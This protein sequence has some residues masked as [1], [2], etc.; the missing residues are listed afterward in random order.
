M[1]LLL[2]LRSLGQTPVLMEDGLGE[3]G[4][5]GGEIDRAIVVVGDEDLGRRRG[6]IGRQLAI[7]LGKGGAV[8]P[9]VDEQ[10]ALAELGLDAL[11]TANELRAKDQNLNLG[12]VGAVLDLI[13]GIAEVEGDR[14]SARLQNAEVDGE[15]LQAVIHQNGNLVTLLHAPGNEHVGKTVGLLIEHIPGNLPSV[16]LV[17]GRLDQIILLPGHPAGL[18]DLRVQLNQSHFIAI[19]LDVAFQKIDNRHV[20]T[21]LSQLCFSRAKNFKLYSFKL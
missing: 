4:G 7:T 20:G 14:Q 13:G 18:L 11:N 3:A 1:V 19:E 5:A 2:H 9:Y 10:T 17:S 6:A 12:Q 8:V 15:P 21:V 16:G